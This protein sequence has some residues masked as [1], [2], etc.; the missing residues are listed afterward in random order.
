MRACHAAPAL[1]TR[2]VAL[3]RLALWRTQL[4]RANLCRAV[5]PLPLW[6][7]QVTS[8]EDSKPSYFACFKWFGMGRDAGGLLERTLPVSPTDPRGAIAEYK[9][10][11]VAGHVHFD[12]FK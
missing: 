6:C 8:E 2:A 3:C 9:V 12:E 4:A 11:G 5:P 7:A 10:R 1:T